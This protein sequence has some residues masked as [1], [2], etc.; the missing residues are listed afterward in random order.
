M[1]ISSPLHIRQ[2]DAFFGHFVE[3]RKFAEALYRLDDAVGDV[4][5]FGFGVEAADAEA[6][7][8]VGQIVAGAESF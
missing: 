1:R 5:D 8:A 4:V 2:V 6:D 3:R 7:G